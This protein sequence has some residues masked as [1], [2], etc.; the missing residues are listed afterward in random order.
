M[1]LDRAAGLTEKIGRYEKLKAAAS[2]A[3]TYKTRASQFE[4]VRIKLAETQKA[5][6]QFDEAAIP[7]AFESTNATQLLT[8]ANALRDQ[9]VADPGVITSPPFDLK[10]EFVDRISGLTDFARIA[11]ENAWRSY[12]HAQTSV[13][14]SEVLDALV[15]LPQFRASVVSIKE[16]NGN[17][18]RLA[19]QIPTNLRAAVVSLNQLAQQ[20][21]SAWA[22]ISADD[23]PESVIKFLRATAAEGVS[24][25]MLS[26]ETRAWLVAKGLLNAFRIRIG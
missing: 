1:L 21:R 20:L 14:S 18:N 10:Y 9:F 26:E 4:Q 16:C 25:D 23:I 2:Q 13:G 24:L 11:L 15:Q 22:A 17:V 6:R 7:V 12:V 19:A 8:N 5:V 3:Q